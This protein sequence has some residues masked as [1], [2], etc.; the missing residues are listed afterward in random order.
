MCLLYQLY[1]KVTFG[2]W[3]EVINKN[4]RLLTSDAVDSSYALHQASGI[5]R[6][7]IVQN[8]VC[9]MKVDSF[10]QNL[11]GDDYLIVVFPLS[12]I[13]GIEVLTY[14]RLHV[15]AVGCRDGK[16]AESFVFARSCQRLHRIYS[17]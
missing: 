5:P 12:T 8:A 10:R 16:S 2:T 14:L 13:V 11:S 7:I 4:N 9:P 6:S 1:L 15:L 17:L 3:H